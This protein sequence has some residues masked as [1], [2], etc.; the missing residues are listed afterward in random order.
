M[1]GGLRRIGHS[2]Q[3][4]DEETQGY[5]AVVTITREMLNIREESGRFA[6]IAEYAFSDITV[7]ALDED[8]RLYERRLA[9]VSQKKGS[10]PEKTTSI[11]TDEDTTRKLGVYLEEQLRQILNGGFTVQDNPFKEGGKII[12]CVNTQRLSFTVDL[13]ADGAVTNSAPAARV[14]LDCALDVLPLKKKENVA[15]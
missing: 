13:D 6:L 12:C 8:G 5:D 10:A 15:D 7:A 2:Y 4:L 14:M 11:Q 9:D 1:R 3:V